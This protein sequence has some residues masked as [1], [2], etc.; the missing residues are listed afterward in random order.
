MLRY[1]TFVSNTKVTTMSQFHNRLLHFINQK[2]G[3]FFFSWSWNGCTGTWPNFFS[4]STTFTINI[5]KPSPWGRQPK[6]HEAAYVHQGGN[7]S[8]KLS[9]LVITSLTKV[10]MEQISKSVKICNLKIRVKLLKIYFY[11]NIILTL[12]Q[13]LCS[14][15]IFPKTISSCHRRK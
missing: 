15:L 12:L 7:N 5:V 4:V 9:S 11:H 10:Y 6:P 8:I 1:Y 3:I 13:R 2:L 14:L